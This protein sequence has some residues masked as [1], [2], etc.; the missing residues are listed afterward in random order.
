LEDGTFD[1]RAFGEVVLGSYRSLAR[2]AYLMSGDPTAAEDMV[3]EAFTR[4]WI[5]WKNGTVDALEPYVRRIVVNLC[6]QGKRRRFL[7][8]RRDQRLLV[9]GGPMTHA[10]GDQTTDHIDLRRGLLALSADHRAV[11]VLR[12]YAD[13]SEQET[14]DVLR[15]PVGTIKSRTSRALKALRPLMER[16]AD[17]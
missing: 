15:L 4:A 5:P 13:L 1:D 14:A 16:T 11:I 7:D 2:V 9:E 10:V 6:L 8:W 3:A 12:F 17:E